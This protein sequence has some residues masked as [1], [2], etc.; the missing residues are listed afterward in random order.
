MY[1]RS[2]PRRRHGEEFNAKVLADC[3]EPGAS[4]SGVALA[5]GLNANLVRQWRAVKLVGTAVA[6]PS[7]PEGSRPPKGKSAP[8]IAAGAECIA[9]EM[10]PPHKNATIAAVEPTLPP[11]P[12]E[13]QHI[14]VELR[15]GSLHL[16][17]RWPTAAV[18]DCRAWLR[19]LAAGLAK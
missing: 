2:D 12:R 17:V 11:A 13:E 4:I 1:S 8:Q 9:L 6:A 3:D 16:N 18:D 19:E 7:A 10:A 15:R 5:H 14:H